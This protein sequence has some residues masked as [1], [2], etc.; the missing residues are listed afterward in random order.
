[1][2]HRL[3][4]PIVPDKETKRVKQFDEGKILFYALIFNCQVACL[5]DTTLYS[6]EFEHVFVHFVQELMV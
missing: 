4:D 1:M 2:E 5:S 3:I 6:I